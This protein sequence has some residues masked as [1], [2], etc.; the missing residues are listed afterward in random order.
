MSRND[1]DITRHVVTVRVCHWLFALSGMLLVFSGIGFMPLYGRFYLNDLPG[2]QWVSDFAAQ[3]TLHYVAAMLFVA[4]GMF[5]LVYHWR[6]GET[7]L[8][9][10]RGD[11]IASW[12]IVKALLTG[13]EGPPHDK[14]LAEQRLAWA[15]FVITAIILAA[16]GYFLALKTRFGVIL[17][18]GLIQ[19]VTLLHMALTFV[20]ILQVLMHLAA[21]ILKANRPL[22]LSMFHGRVNREYV[23]QRHARWQQ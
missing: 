3:M 4:T 7:A 14:F 22:L 2:M 9:P 20:F 8:L 11:V 17:D 21:F 10:R 1:H 18:P 6:R 5:H 12:Q 16:S 13:G 19:V 23:R 15:G